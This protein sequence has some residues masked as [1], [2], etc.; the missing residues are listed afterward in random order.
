MNGSR[1]CDT[2]PHNG[3]L[4]SH[5]KDETRLFVDKWMELE[6]IMLSE[7]SQVQK[8]KEL[9]DS[10]H[11]WEIDPKDKHMHTQTYL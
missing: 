2:H 6:D 8:D 9:H 10:S 4:F 5:K 7:V 3:V 1:K 11:M